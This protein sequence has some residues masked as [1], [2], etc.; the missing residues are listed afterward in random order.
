MREIVRKVLSILLIILVIFSINSV[1]TYAE[2]DDAENEETSYEEN[3]EEENE[4]ETSNTKKS[5]FFLYD[6]RIN[7]SK[8]KSVIKSISPWCF[9][10]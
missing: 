5:S 3:S 2:E 10:W 8:R 4:E 7:I 6:F 9:S 1:F